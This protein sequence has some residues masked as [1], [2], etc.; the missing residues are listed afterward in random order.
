MC[1][2]RCL[3][4]TASGDNQINYVIKIQF[5]VKNSKQRKLSLKKVT[6]AN[7]LASSLGGLLIS[8]SF[9]WDTVP[10][11]QSISPT[12]TLPMCRSKG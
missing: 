1:V 3:I 9:L 10:T 4:G 7:L 8:D 11:G 5:M 12:S 2:S 6:V